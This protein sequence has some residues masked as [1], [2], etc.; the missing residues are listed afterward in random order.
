MR[1]KL[2][3]AT[4]V[5]SVS[6]PAISVPVV[7]ADSKQFKDLPTTNPYYDIIQE[8]R[9]ALIINGYP[10][11]TFKP[12]ESIS[13]K[14]VASLLSRSL[15]LKEVNEF[16]E[17]VDVPTTHPYYDVIKQVQLAGIFDG[18]TNGEFKP[19]APITRVQ[20]AKVLDLAFDLQGSSEHIF[21]DVSR[22]H[23]GNQYVN[24]LYSN[25]IT[26][27]DNGYFKPQDPVTRAHY[28]I[29]LY[30]ALNVKNQPVP[31]EP[32][33]PTPEI[34]T[35]TK[36]TKELESL[37]KANPG[38]FLTKAQVSSNPFRGV[39][40]PLKVWT[41]GNATVKKTGLKYFLQYDR[42]YGAKGIELTYDGYKNPE[43]RFGNVALNFT[44]ERDG[45]V[46]LMYDFRLDSANEVAKEYI[47]IAFPQYA[48]EIIPLIDPKV[49]Q[50]REGEKTGDTLHGNKEYIE[51]ENH[52]LHIGVNLFYE[53]MLLQFSVKN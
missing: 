19:E 36:A 17:F 4:L 29:F 7:V 42:E 5:A 26:T 52:E 27:G 18:D 33:K 45:Y 1:R 35:P 37:K 41:E 12:Q 15:P 11:G 9:D 24:A 46:E 6:I 38:M 32:V 2:F 10:D 48:D 43:P 23:W 13:R 25:G 50:A 14:H 3:M 44:A 8:M 22:S 21:P 49:L 16:K 34:E 47:R 40:V 20:M 28:A 30:R 51:L 39:E 31:V 53:W